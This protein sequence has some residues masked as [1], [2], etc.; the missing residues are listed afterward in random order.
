MPV[1]DA[2]H[3]VITYLRVSV[4]DRCNLRCR[5]CMPGSGVKKLP[6][7]EILR[8]EEILKIIN[9]VSQMGFKKVRITGGEPLVRKN[10]VFFIKEIKKIEGIEKICLTTNGTLLPNMAEKLYKAGL[11]HINISLDTLDRKKYAYITRR[12][13]FGQVWKG[14]K[15]VIELGFDPIKINVVLIKGFNDDEIVD[16]AKLSFE[17][18]LAVRFIE[19]MPLNHTQ[20]EYGH[21]FLSAEEAISRLKKLGKLEPI[22]SSELDG[23]AKR[24]KIKG[25]LGEIGFITAL[26]DHFCSKCNRLRLT[27]DGQ[28]RPCLFSN[29]EWDLKTPLRQGANEA[30]IKRIIEDAIAHKPKNHGYVKF[31]SRRPMSWIGG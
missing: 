19:F 5:Y 25:S 18:P 8:Y 17:Y 11:R 21:C 2:F 9:V 3:R 30:E 4:T 23:P 1:C 10:I 13:A 6:H 28:L 14:I 7:K 26:S 31:I 15:R 16:L 29:R 24:Y 20:L 22:P 12:D 27:P